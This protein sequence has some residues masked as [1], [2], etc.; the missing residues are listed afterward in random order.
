MPQM[1]PTMIPTRYHIWSGTSRI[2]LA[3]M[4][5][6]PF[7]QITGQMKKPMHKKMRI[8]LGSLLTPSMKASQRDWRFFT[9]LD[10]LSSEVVPIAVTRLKALSATLLML[11]HIALCSQA[12]ELIHLA[13][14]S[15]ICFNF[16]R[17]DR[18]CS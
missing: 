7:A 4:R 13:A 3:Q 1:T 10:A 11:L 12:P 5:K 17:I 6:S 18:A 8:V 16:D 9:G 2:A 15:I 14:I